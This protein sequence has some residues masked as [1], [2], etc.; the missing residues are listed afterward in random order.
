MS[1]GQVAALLCAIVLLLPGGCYVVLGIGFGPSLLRIGIGILA[2]AALLFWIASRRRPPLI[3]ALALLLPGGCFLF[4]GVINLRR[5]SDISDFAP[6][7][8]IVGLLI[9]S[10]TVWQFWVA[11][12]R[13]PGRGGPPAPP[14]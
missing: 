10:A 2:V 3:F 4:F 5:D 9:L 6:L 14:T 11:F 12:R 13:R 8:I 1:G 7:M